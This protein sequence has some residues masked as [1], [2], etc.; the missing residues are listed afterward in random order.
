MLCYCGRGR[1][2]EE[3]NGGDLVKILCAF[4]RVPRAGCEEVTLSPHVPHRLLA[5]DQ[6]AEHGPQEYG[7]T[8]GKG[9]TEK[10]LGQVHTEDT[11]R[12]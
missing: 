7:P 10:P 6:C 2:K 5:G 4:G 12:H 9:Q 8:P 3:R 11:C 1:A